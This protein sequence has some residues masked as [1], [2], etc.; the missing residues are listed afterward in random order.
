MSLHILWDNHTSRP[1][2]PTEARLFGRGRRCKIKV[3]T[4]CCCRKALATETVCRL[5]CQEFPVG[6][7]GWY[8]DVASW[9]GPDGYPFSFAWEPSYYEPTW[10]I[11]CNPNGGCNKDKKKLRGKAAP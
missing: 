8:Q 4:D 3:V 11:V 1:W 6:D 2:W 9:P 5:R 10:Q 7:W